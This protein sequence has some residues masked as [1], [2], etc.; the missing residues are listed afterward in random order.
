MSKF[1]ERDDDDHNNRGND[2]GEGNKRR[3]PLNATPLEAYGCLLP[4][5]IIVLLILGSWL[6]A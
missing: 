3:Y 1:N 4:L 2:D 6:F 5:G